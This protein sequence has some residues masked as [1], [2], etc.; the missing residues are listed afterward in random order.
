ML[1]HV[2]TS[3][4]PLRAD[5]ERNRQR[6][7][8]AAGELFAEKGLCVGLDEIAR[9]AGVGVG[10]AYRRFPDKEQL[11]DALFEEHIA[12]LEAVGQQALA[13]DDPWAGLVHFMEGAVELQVANRGLKE[14]LFRGPTNAERVQRARGR[15]AP[16]VQEVV[17]RAQ[18]AGRLRA[19]VAFT[20][21]PLLHFMLASLSELS[22]QT[23]GHWRRYLGVILDGLR[24]PDPTPLE[25]PALTQDELED[26]L[27]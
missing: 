2:T 14:L 10:T 1:T 20:D 22:P 23:A 24:A 27:T 21:I 8:T 3:E 18:K 4:R 16:L 13:D 12:R 11:I 26:A 15:I 17:A 5:A 25:P 9:H 6:L 7:L 19:D